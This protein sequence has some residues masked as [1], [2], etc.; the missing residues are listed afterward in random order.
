MLDTRFALIVKTCELRRVPA[1]R[2]G[3]NELSLANARLSG[4]EREDFDALTF[5]QILESKC[6]SVLEL[7]GV[8]IG[9]AQFSFREF[10]DQA[11][12]L[13]RTTIHG[14]HRNSL[15]LARELICALLVKDTVLVVYALGTRSGNTQQE[16]KVCIELIG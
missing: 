15:S 8:S 14:S 5:F 13:V 1:L 4:G 6:H 7:N 12:P 10:Q 9:H 2:L 3:C 11:F 16:W